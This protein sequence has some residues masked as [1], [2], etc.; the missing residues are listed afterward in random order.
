MRILSVHNE[1]RERTG[2][3]RA[4]RVEREALERAGHAVIP[5]SRDSAEIG[6]YALPRRLLLPARAFWSRET[7]AAVRAAVRRHRPDVAHVH[8]IFPLI[9]PSVYAALRREGVPVVQTVHNFRMWCACGTLYRCGPACSGGRPPIGPCLRRGCF[10]NSRILTAWVAAI[11]AWHWRRKT[12][13][14]IRLYI[15]PSEW[16]RG[17]LVSFG[18]PPERVA[19][20]PHFLTDDE[21]A[22]PPPPAAGP[23]YALCASWLDEHKG[24]RTLAQAAALAPHIPFK[25]AGTGPLLEPLRARSAPNVEWLGH[26]P[27]A[28][29]MALMGG[30]QVVVCPSQWEEPFGL[31]LIEAFSRGRAIVGSRIGAIPELVAD[32]Q[33]GLLV[34]PGDAPAL[35]AAIRALWDDPDRCARMGDYNR[36]LFNRR[37]REKGN[38][39]QLIA[40][41]ARAMRQPQ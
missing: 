32:P 29:V 41:Y 17:R 26:R 35:A 34:P 5:F 33:G 10:K 30:A 37:F 38:V 3:H 19:V 1:Y 20:K 27:H 15:A 16:V 40:L 9:S 25:V 6:A 2:E 11:H 14:A 21:A 28:E 8:N 12:F 22:A 24:A 23:R 13:D 36:E 31:V 7:V 4:V 39:E 18:L